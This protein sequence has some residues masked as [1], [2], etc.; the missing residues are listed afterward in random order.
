RQATMYAFL[1]AGWVLPSLIAPALAG[2]VTEHFGWRWVFLGI[3]PFGFAVG[4]LAVQPMRRYGPVGDGRTVASRIPAALGAALGIG[5][6]V[7]GLELANLV[8]AA[9]TASIGLCLALPSLRR[10]FPEGVGRARRGLPAVIACRMLATATFLGVDSFVPLAAD[11]IHGAAPRVQGFVIIGAALTWTV[12]QWLTA[13]RPPHNPGMPVRW[14]FVFLM[15]GTVLVAPVLDRGWPL[16][17]T[18]LAWCVGG[19][20]MGILFNPSTVAAM[21]YAE[22]GHEGLVSGQ[23]SLADAVGF[24]MMGGV[25]GAMVAFADR[26]SLTLR[27][28]LASNFSIA[29]LLACVGIVA[30]RGVRRA[31]RTV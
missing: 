31:S 18:F 9:I 12:G 6:L 15:L 27:G 10:L 16:W 7:T 28:A 22:Q 1:S 8:V 4:A 25:G 21:S 2:S 20:G 29:I 23:L 26:T 3:V 19:F 11:R 24:S 30:S 17:A 5:L 13:R 14:G